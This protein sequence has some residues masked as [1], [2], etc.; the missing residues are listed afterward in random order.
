VSATY[1]PIIFTNFGQIIQVSINQATVAMIVENQSLFDCLFSVS[2]IQPQPVTQATAA[3]LIAAGQPIV[4]GG[5]DLHIGP[6]QAGVL[7]VPESSLTQTSHGGFWTGTLYVQLVQ[8]T[9]TSVVGGSFVSNPGANIWITAYGPDEK[10]P[11]AGLESIG[12]FLASQERNIAVPVC[13]IFYAGT[14]QLNTATSTFQ[15][16][17]SF[18]IGNFP[19][20][21]SAITV[22]FSSPGQVFPLLYSC[23]ATMWPLSAVAGTAES[24]QVK[25][26]FV[27]YDSV[28]T[29]VGG[30]AQFFGDFFEHLALQGANARSTYFPPYPQASGFTCAAGAG[31][32]YF[33]GIQMLVDNATGGG[34]TNIKRMSL[35][36]V[37]DIASTIP[38]GPTGGSSG[39]SSGAVYAGFLY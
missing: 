7:Q 14:A 38:T 24:Q 19:F 37:C 25:L 11:S 5:W 15:P 4:S 3:A 16:V 26:A 27:I 9:N 13:S 18:N 31:P 20:S 30:P 35:N 21:N 39:I 34:G 1:G 17:Q 33:L 22:G 8:V 29:V 32:P 36:V 6:R 2:Q 10:I 23:M 12:Y 28:S